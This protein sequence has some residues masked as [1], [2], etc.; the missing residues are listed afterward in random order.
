MNWDQHYLS[1]ARQVSLKSKDPSTK[2]GAVVVN[3]RNQLVGTGYNGFPVGVVDSSERLNNREE[4]Y[5]FTV[6]A[7]VNAILTAGHQAQGGSLY[8]WCPGFEIP[9]VCHECCKI[10]IQAGIKEIIGEGSVNEALAKRWEISR[11]TATTLCEEAGV[12]YRRVDIETL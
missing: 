7:E 10:A 8:V 12:K 6:H 2:V 5:R 9:Y 4:K 3:T 1:I 11:N